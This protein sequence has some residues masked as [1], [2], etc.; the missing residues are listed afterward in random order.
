M[1]PATI[2]SVALQA[3]LRIVPG[4]ARNQYQLLR[5]PLR[6]MIVTRKIGSETKGWIEYPVL[7]LDCLRDWLLLLYWDILSILPGCW[8]VLDPY[9]Y[10]HYICYEKHLCAWL[11]ISCPGKFL[12]SCCVV[13]SP[14]VVMFLT[15]SPR[16]P[17]GVLFPTAKFWALAFCVVLVDSF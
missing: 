17:P 3:V 15:Y 5:R 11:Y 12:V 6:L 4:R 8:Y 7:G 16:K 2:L 1:T 14:L 9:H 13:F 10:Y